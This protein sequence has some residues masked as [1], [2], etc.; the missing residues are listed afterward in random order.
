M[1]GSVD[2]G[3][4]KLNNLAPVIHFKNSYRLYFCRIFPENFDIRKGGFSWESE[5]TG[6]FLLSSLW[7]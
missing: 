4:V 1:A 5:L 2:I 3:G 7:Y 6:W